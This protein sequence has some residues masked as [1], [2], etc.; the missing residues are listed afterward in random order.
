MPKFEPVRSGIHDKKVQQIIMP[1]HHQR[2]A[3]ALRPKGK[4]AEG[5]SGGASTKRGGA[6][7]SRRGIS[8]APSPKVKI[9]AKKIMV[10]LVGGLL[11]V[12]TFL[13]SKMVGSS[14]G[15]GT[16]TVNSKESQLRGGGG[17]TKTKEVEGASEHDQLAKILEGADNGAAKKA[18][19]R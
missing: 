18:R 12:L 15:T 16:N 5:S 2:G 17:G 11:L 13:L 10:C 14:S 9:S 3:P 4:K 6:I 8:G 7:K 19:R 1:K